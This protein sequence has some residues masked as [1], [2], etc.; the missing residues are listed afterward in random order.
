[1]AV[2]DAQQVGDDGVASAALHVGVDDARLDA[3]LV[4]GV[5]MLV[6]QEGADGLD[7][8]ERDA[9][10]HHLQESLVGATDEL[11]EE[12]RLHGDNVVGRETEVQID[13][14]EQ[15]VHEADHL[16]DH[17]VLSHVVAVLHHH[18]Q[19][20]E[21]QLVAAVGV[22]AEPHALSLHAALSAD[23]VFTRAAVMLLRSRAPATP[24]CTS[25][26]LQIAQRR[27]RHFA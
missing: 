15:L 8:R 20:L 24:A 16:D 27:Q 10:L 6:L 1:M 19:D 2:T 7:A 13:V 25:N 3:Q 11:R 22:R 4:R 5:G 26:A 14:L 21:A 12:A 17:L 18:A 23:G 9:V